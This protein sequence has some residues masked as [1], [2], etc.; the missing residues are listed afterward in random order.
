MLFENNAATQGFFKNKSQNTVPITL[1][2]VAA[3]SIDV[4]FYGSYRWRLV[5]D[6]L[7]A[8]NFKVDDKTYLVIKEVYSKESGTYTLT[9]CLRWIMK[10]RKN[11][12]ES[13][14]FL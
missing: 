2:N 10:Y 5:V 1:K 13:I 4:E 12:I 11:L 8:V 3:T 9:E 14:C 6:P 7:N